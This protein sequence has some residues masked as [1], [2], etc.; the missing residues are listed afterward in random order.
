MKDL[1]AL[2]RKLLDLLQDN[3]RLSLTELGGRTGIAPSTVND[4][5]HRLVKQGAISGFHARLSPEVVG[6]D[7]LTFML[8]GWSDPKV[9]AKFLARMKASRAVLECHHVTGAWNY[10][11]KV[12]V[13]NTRELED[14]I[15][16]TVKA[17]KG[18]QRTET[19]IALSS[20]K[21]SW[22]LDVS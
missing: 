12:R 6:M 17:V 20:P 5:I 19:L 9:E 3:D 1:D 4:R 8:V 10:L 14:F 18:V 13:R 7:I 15:G 16:N 2:D 21:E 22:A 11:L